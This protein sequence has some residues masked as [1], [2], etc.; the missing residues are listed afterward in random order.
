MCE[1]IK[2]LKSSKIG[3]KTVENGGPGRGRFWVDF[4]PGN[5]REN[6]PDREKCVF[7]GIGPGQKAKMG[8]KNGFF[9]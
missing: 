3:K 4:R 8:L 5:A 6:G 7:F 9:A 1:L 2:R